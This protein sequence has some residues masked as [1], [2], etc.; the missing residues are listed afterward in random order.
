MGIQRDRIATKHVRVNPAL[1][2]HAAE[3][4]GCG[5]AVEGP[6]PRI[7]SCAGPV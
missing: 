2:T 1:S 5:L 7:A 6:H 3:W 4:Q